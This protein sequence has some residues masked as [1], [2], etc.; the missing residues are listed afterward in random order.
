MAD[1]F[2][3]ED[4]GKHYRYTYKGIK[5]DPARIASIY[6][7]NHPMQLGIIKK[8]LCAG[9]RGHKDK[10]KDIQDIITA[11]ERWLEMLKEDEE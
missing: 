8:V 6:S 2:K 4:K 7:A 9:S 10:V 5:L 11:A 1:E 3:H